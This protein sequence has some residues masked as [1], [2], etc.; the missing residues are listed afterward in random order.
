MAAR[1]WRGT[2]DGNWGSGGAGGNWSTT[3]GGATGAAVPTSADDVTFDTNGNNNCTINT[4]S[5]VCLSLTVT[6]GYTATI[7]HSQT[8][9][10][11]GNVTFNNTHTIAGSSTLAINAASTITMN[12]QIWPNSLTLNGSAIFT[13]NTNLSISGSLVS[14]GATINK[15]TTETLTCYGISQTQNIGGSAKIILKGGSWSQTG[16]RQVSNALDIDGNITIS[17]TVYYVGT[18]T[19]I[20]GTVSGTGTLTFNNSSTLNLNGASFYNITFASGTYTLTSSLQC[21]GALASTAT[22]TLNKTASEDVTSSGGMNGA[23]AFAGTAK[24]IL[25]GGTWSSLSS[26]SN[27][28]DLNGNVTLSGSVTFRA[29]TLTYVSGTITVTSSTLVLSA[30]CTLDTS[31]MSFNNVTLSNTSAQVYTINSTLTTDGILTLG[32]GATTNFSGTSGFST[33]T[34]LCTSTG[35]ITINFKESVTYTI[36]TAFNCFTSRAGS[37]VLFTS[38]HASTKAII[39]MPNNGS[40]TCNVLASFTRIDASAGRSINTFGGTITDCLNVNQ[41]YDYKTTTGII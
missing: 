26:V 35:A 17:A 4:S 15:T 1:Y 13:L 38:S 21:S 19:Y 31:G 29:G 14:G 24:I 20:S 18:I 25:T 40:N 9:T 32:T 33:A 34:L 27:D 6:S 36:T 39:T 22:A 23:G 7:T 16:T 3:S 28:L 8:L 5:R 11:S 41:F 30:S 2:G 12:G 37:I 10:V